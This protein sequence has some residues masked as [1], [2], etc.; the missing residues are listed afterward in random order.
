MGLGVT[1]L[2]MQIVIASCSISLLWIVRLQLPLLA[3]LR[4]L[5][6]ELR[7]RLPVL[8]LLLLAAQLELFLGRRVRLLPS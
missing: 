1:T 2:A 8:P 4:A 3:R 5:C 7:L 6:V